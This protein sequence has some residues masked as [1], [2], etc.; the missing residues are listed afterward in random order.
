MELDYKIRK[1]L[2]SDRD[3]VLSMMKTFYSSAAVY[4]NGSDEIFNCDI[5][6]CISDEPYL[7]GFIF[8]CNNKTAGYLMTARSF[9]TEFGKTCIWL[10]DLYLKPEF[11]GMGIAADFISYIKKLNP[12]C[13]LRL[14]VENENS[15]AVHVYEKS[16]FK[17]LPYTEMINLQ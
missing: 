11:R 12:D 7:E 13:V 4:T 10:E 9:S 14:E 17:P 16:G 5:D 2:N 8:E 3:E 1:M 6:N 15:H